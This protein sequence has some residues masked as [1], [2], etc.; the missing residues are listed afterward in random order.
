MA[1]RPIFLVRSDGDLFVDVDFVEF[2]WIPGLSKSQKQKNIVSL[3]QSALDSHENLKFLEVSSKA[4]TSLGLGLSAFNLG[5]MHPRT[6]KSISVESAFQAS[7][8][9]EKGGPFPELFDMG[10]RE[11]KSYI[12]ALE[13]GELM[14]FD[15]YGQIWPLR[16][17]TAFY[18]WL[19]LQ[20]LRTAVPYCSDVMEFNAFTDIEFNPKKSLNCQAYSAALFVSLSLRNKLESILSDPGLFLDCLKV[21]IEWVHGSPYEKFHAHATDGLF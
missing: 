3:H 10:S 20:S 12:A 17:L 18:D 14:H 2:D 7:K 9:F 4:S 13:F 5:Y 1:V 8:V 16:P 21:Q 15:F 6:K 11:A 19:Y